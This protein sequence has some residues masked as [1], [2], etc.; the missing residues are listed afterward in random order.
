MIKHL[1]I[2]PTIQTDLD[3]L[4]TLARFEDKR[5]VED[6]T[7]RPLIDNLEYG[8]LNAQPCIS[9]RTL[10]GQ[11][12]A[13]IG[14]VPDSKLNH[15]IYG[16]FGRIAMVGT[17]ALPRHRTAVLRG[18]QAYLKTLEKDYDFLHNVCDARNSLH[19]KWLK[20]LGFSVGETH[21]PHGARQ[22]PVHYFYKRCY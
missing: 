13:I 1:D 18:S 14:I 19:I 12:L 22:I 5:E 16:R 20:W 15:E 9:A 7:G 3:E 10:D 2:K 17:Q 21:F 11:L 8:Y 4:N 6:I